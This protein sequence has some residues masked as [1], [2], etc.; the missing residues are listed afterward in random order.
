VVVLGQLELIR[1]V[2]LIS[3]LLNLQ[4]NFYSFS[5]FRWKNLRKESH[6]VKSFG[7]LTNV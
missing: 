7:V 4:L 5:N 2:G 1:L 6:T 3:I